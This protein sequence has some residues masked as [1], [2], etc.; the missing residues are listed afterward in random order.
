MGDPVGK[1]IT[2]KRAEGVAQVVELLPAS[3]R[4]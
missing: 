1:I 3:V 2:A 4:P